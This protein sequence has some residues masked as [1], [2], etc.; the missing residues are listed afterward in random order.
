MIARDQPTGASGEGAPGYFSYAVFAFSLIAGIALGLAMTRIQGPLQ[1]SNAEP[2]QL[3]AEDR[4]HYQIAIALEYAHK[5]DLPGAMK[6]LIAMRP[7]QDPLDALA[8]AACAL[9]SSGYL[10]SESGVRAIRSAVALYSSQ[11]RAG[12]AEQLLPQKAT[13]SAPALATEV[14]PDAGFATPLPT[15]PPLPDSAAD[16]AFRRLA[17]T[18]APKRSFEARSARSYCDAASPALIEARVVDYLGRGIPGQ[19]IRVRWADQE[20]IFVSG[21]KV[22]RGDAYAD[23]QMEEGIEYSIDMPGAADP[24]GASLSTGACYTNNRRT[25]KSWRVTFVEI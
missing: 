25:L 19:R 20:D 6:K 17:P 18:P 9:G 15:K 7:A 3:R 24:L 14:A 4:Q 13:I 10:R 1:R 5:G 11:G 22:G 23:F 2:W 16:V 21:L 12:C 8:D